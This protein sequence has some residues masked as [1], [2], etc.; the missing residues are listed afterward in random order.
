MNITNILAT[1][2]KSSQAPNNVGVVHRDEL[3]AHVL[4]A[5]AK[6]WKPQAQPYV[7]AADSHYICLSEAELRAFI[8]ASLK[9]QLPYE[10]QNDCDDFSWRLKLLATEAARAANVRWTYAVG[11]IWRTT[12]DYARTG[13]A[14]NWALTADKK[15]LL[16]DPQTGDLRSVDSTDRNIDLVCC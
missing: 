9:K 1:L 5:L 2:E 7:F 11:V 15:F 4:R 6:L 13:H 3:T 12:P 14:Y 16:I 8:D 10:K